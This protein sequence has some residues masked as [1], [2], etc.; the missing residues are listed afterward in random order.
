MNS[1]QGR[2][3]SANSVKITHSAVL[4]FYEAM[5]V[6]E[7]RFLAFQYTIQ[8]NCN[9]WTTYKFPTET[10]IEGETPEQTAISGAHQEIPENPSDF[11]FCFAQE[12]PI[13]VQKCDGDPEKGG[14]IHEKIVFLLSDL[15][16]ELRK[17]AKIEKGKHGRG[18]ETLSPPRWYEAAEL[19]EL[20]EER[21]VLFH[22]IALLRALAVLAKDSAVCKRYAGIIS[23]ARYQQY[24][25]D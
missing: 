5:G 15:R 6:G 23:D 20:M 22:R 3:N 7:I 1:T 16:G 10:G 8:K 13:Y 12:K 19:F 9:P 25:S 24:L 18:D 21:G 17:T 4:V 11:G 14:G 2:P